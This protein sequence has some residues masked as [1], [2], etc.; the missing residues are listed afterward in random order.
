VWF[1]GRIKFYVWST[2]VV[3]WR[4]YWFLWPTTAAKEIFFT[5]ESLPYSSPWEPQISR[6]NIC[7]GDGR[8]YY[9]DTFVMPP[10]ICLRVLEWAITVA[11]RTKAWIVFARSNTGIVGSNPSRG[12]DVCVRFYC[13]C[14]VLCVGS[15]LATG[16]SPVQGVLPLCIDQETAKAAKVHKGCRAIRR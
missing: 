4:L 15:G 3:T 16:W 10:F 11:A 14:I 9:K 5:Y 6:G 8:S 7:S 12:V 2:I 1:L 13:V